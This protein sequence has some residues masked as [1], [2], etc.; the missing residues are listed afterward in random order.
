VRTITPIADYPRPQDIQVRLSPIDLGFDL[1][2]VG[3]TVQLPGNTKIVSYEYEGAHLVVTGSLDEIWETLESAGYT[4]EDAMITIS[5]DSGEYEFDLDEHGLLVA[6]RRKG[7]PWAT[8]LALRHTNCFVAAL[9]RIAE[10]ED[11]LD[12]LLDSD[13]PE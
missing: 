12:H 10:L 5:L 4:V 8:G 3:T 1:R 6:A 7:E 2:T 9:Q 11:K 13:T